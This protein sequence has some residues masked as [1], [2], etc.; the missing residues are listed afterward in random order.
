MLLCHHLNGKQ[1]SK[2]KTE[3]FLL[4]W[5]SR[6]NKKKTQQSWILSELG[7]LKLNSA[8]FILKTEFS[9]QCM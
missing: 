7:I 5:N 1:L 8:N 6:K 3:V 9:Q 2:W 4:E